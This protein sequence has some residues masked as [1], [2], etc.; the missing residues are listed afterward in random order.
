MGRDRLWGGLWQVGGERVRAL[1]RRWIAFL[2]TISDE[3]P[4]PG[5]EHLIISQK[6]A[7]KFA[8]RK[9]A[10]KHLQNGASWAGIGAGKPGAWSQRNPPEF[11][12]NLACLA[13]SPL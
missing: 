10:R 4:V 13:R 1:I 11:G 8:F 9:S 6:I 7:S 5:P 12:L 3:I 2:A